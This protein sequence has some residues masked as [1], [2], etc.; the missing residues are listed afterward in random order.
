MDRER[1][2]A[3]I[4]DFDGVIIDSEP[5]HAEAKRITLEHFQIPYAP[6]LFSDFKGRTD[7][8]FFDFVA[9]GLAPGGF[10]AAELDAY[11]RLEYQRLFADVP[12]VPGVLDFIHAARAAYGKIGLASSA[13]GRDF[14]LALQK[15]GIRDWFDVMVTG[16]DTTRHKPHPEPYLKAMSALGVTAAETLVIEDSPNGI[17]SARQAGCRIAALTTT[18]GAAELV[19]VS[20]DL[21]G[22]S[23]V[24]LGR[25][26]GIFEHKEKK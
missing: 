3:C 11:K 16:D 26:L 8:D 12:L 22:D 5:L 13:T 10:S 14:S 6:T 23:F 2:A 9:G 25:L 4:F 24:E 17:R 1:F 20:A 19:A 7:K 18:F 21:V 15:Y